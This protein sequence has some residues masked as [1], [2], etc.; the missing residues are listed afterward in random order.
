MKE[1][2]TYEYGAMS[3]K[4]ALQADNKL[5][6]YAT[7]I[8]HFGNS[9]H[10]IAL[11]SPEECKNDSWLNIT[12]QVA[13]RIDEVFGGDGAFEKYVE[14]HVDEIRACYQTIKQLV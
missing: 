1:I 7:M 11:Y 12:G 4:Y 13:E 9:N 8:C 10:L 2:T 5:T 6:A 14:E 3:S